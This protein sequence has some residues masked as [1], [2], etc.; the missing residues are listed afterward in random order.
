MSAS[1]LMMK[2]A[3]NSL[4]L[5]KRSRQEVHRLVHCFISFQ[6]LIALDFITRRKT[7]PILLQYSSD[8]TPLATTRQ[9]QIK[10][11]DWTCTRHDKAKQPW[12]IQRGFL[13]DIAGH[14]VAII[15]RP[16]IMENK[17]AP[18]QF[19]ASRHFMKT[20]REHGHIDIQI[21]HHVYYRAVKSSVEMLILKHHKYQMQQLMQEK[22][23]ST[24]FLADLLT[25]HSIVG[26][27]NHDVHNA[28][29]WCAAEFTMN[30]ITLN[31][32]FI[33]TSAAR[34]GRHVL[35]KHVSEWMS[36]SLIVFEDWEGMGDDDLKR[37]YEII[38][39]TPEII[40]VFIKMQIR[41]SG[42]KMRTIEKEQDRATH[43]IVLAV[44]Q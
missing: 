42:G 21:I 39:I 25:G 8:E 36:P 6:N 10:L 38:G 44:E 13:A 41:Y 29:K 7:Q 32:A 40:N 27:V 37:Y 19:M 12:L 11:D 17:K 34:N 24:S 16:M 9:I 35:I 20:P 14:V 3:D 1:A 23:E 4:V 30:A 2:Y 43:G 22:V 28:L 15:D 26:C 31:G 5:E 33:S 18:T